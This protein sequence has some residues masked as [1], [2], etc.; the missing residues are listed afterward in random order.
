MLMTGMSS[1]GFQGCNTQM[2]QA[3][4]HLK[5]VAHQQKQIEARLIKLNKEEERAQKRIKEAQRKSEFIARMHQ[6]KEEKLMMKQNA[7]RELKEKEELSR[8]RINNERNLH[9]VNLKSH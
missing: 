3:K 4:N 2:M 7:M 5:M 9:R 8:S 1:F 6:I